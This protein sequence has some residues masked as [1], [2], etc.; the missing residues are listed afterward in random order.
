MINHQILQDVLSEYKKD[1][2]PN[3]WHKEKYKWEAVRWFQEHWDIDAVDFTVMLEEALAK[4]A[5]LLDVSKQF[6]RKMIVRMSTWDAEKIRSMFKALFDEKVDVFERIEIFKEDVSSFFA[7]HNQGERNHY[8][9]ENVITVYLWLRY[10]DKYYIY[11]YGEVRKVANKLQSNYKIKKGKPKDNLPQFLSLY[12]ELYELIKTDKELLA[13]FNSQK[14]DACYADSA[15]KT[16]TNDVGF[17]IS[18]YYK[19]ETISD[20]DALNSSVE[21]LSSAPSVTPDVSKLYGQKE[22][23]NEVYMSAAQ[24]DELQ[25]LLHTKKNVIL[26]GAPGVGKTFAARR[27]AYLMMGTKDERRVKFVQFHQNYTYEDFIMGYKP[28]QDGGFT[29]R[30]GVFYSFCKQAQNDPGHDYFFIIDE[31]NRGNLSK[32]FGE[33]MMLIENSYRGERHA[34]RLAYSDELFFVP[35]NLYLI[36]MMN[37]ADRSLAMIDYALRR[38]FSFFEM[39]P[40]FDT[41]GFKTYQKALGSDELD[42]VIAGVVQMNEAIAKDDALGKGFYIGHSYFCNQTQ[43]DRKWLL[44]VMHYDIVPMLEEYWFD[45]HEKCDTQVRKLMAVFDD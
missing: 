5:N 30:H 27:L 38:R 44:N 33:L 12:N 14:D 35:E 16:L 24:S 40:G 45:D 6:P 15:Y 36:G 13:L 10:P 37:T 22:F 8:Q 19:Q 42:K 41:E 9:T 29:L 1:F 28:T 20:S 26:Q 39:R 4:T 31:I 32:I 17:Y 7:T 18:R 3:T 11:K 43:Y 23:L 34:V 25:L 21:H 2:I